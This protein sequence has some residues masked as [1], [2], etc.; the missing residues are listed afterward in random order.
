MKKSILAA[1]SSAILLLAGT[2]PA[3]AWTGDVELGYSNSSGNT[4]NTTLNAKLDVDKAKGSW[5]HNIFGDVYYAETD[6]DKTAERYAI[7][8]KP[9]YFLTEKDYVFGLLR[10]DSDEFT[11][12]DN[13]TTEVVGY[14]RLFLNDNKYY[15]DG[16]IGAG[17]RQTDYIEDP[18][19]ADLKEDEIIG[20]LGTKLSARLSANARFL[21]TLR[22]EIGEDNNYIESITGLQLAIAGDF[23]ASITHTVRHNTDIEGVKGDKTDQVTG[24]NL[25]YSF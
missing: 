22:V 5:R 14:G 7:G 20:F 3:S 12:I 19:I 9:R 11:F 25:V 16:E 17:A 2:A 4:D 24:V 23:S 15:W 6:N 21:E 1:S 18:S 8:Y 13:Q 10:Y